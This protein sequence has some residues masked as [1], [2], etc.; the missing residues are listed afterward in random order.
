MPCE[1]R[2]FALAYRGRSTFMQSLK[3]QAAQGDGWYPSPEQAVV[4]LRIR[5]R[6]ASGHVFSHQKRR[7]NTR[8]PRVNVMR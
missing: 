2:N 4:A 1:A 6:E 7:R 8:G 5:G 3:E